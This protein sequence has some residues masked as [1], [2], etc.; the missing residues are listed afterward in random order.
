MASALLDA[1]A[2]VDRASD[3]G[4]TPLR[5]ACQGGHAAVVSVLLAPGAVVNRAWDNDCTPLHIA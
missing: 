3:N 1:G 5:I 2:V 4:C